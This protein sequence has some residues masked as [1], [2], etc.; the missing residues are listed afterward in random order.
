[1]DFTSLGV[2]KYTLNTYFEL[3]KRP[4]DLTERNQGRWVQIP[5]NRGSL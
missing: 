1:M 3:N 2:K 5:E 4:R